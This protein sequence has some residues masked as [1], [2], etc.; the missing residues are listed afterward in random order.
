MFCLGMNG[1]I[2][3]VHTRHKSHDLQFDTKSLTFSRCKT[4]SL[5]GVFEHDDH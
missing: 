4:Q 5:I 1:E 3:V 2:D